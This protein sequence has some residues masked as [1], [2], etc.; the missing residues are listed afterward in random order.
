MLTLRN[1]DPF[2]DLFGFSPFLTQRP[3]PAGGER[4]FIPAVDIYETDEAHVVEVELAGMKAEDVDIEIDQG[5]LSLKG[6]RKSGRDIDE[7]GYKLTERVYGSF[8]RSFRLPDTVDAENIS[9]DLADGVLKLV[10][11][12]RELERPRKIA[13]KAES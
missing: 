1:R 8:T 7:E 3:A 2:T 6:E 9:A 12:K 13:V 4:R 5:V 11:P 10:L